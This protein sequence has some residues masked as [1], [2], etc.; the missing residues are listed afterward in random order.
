MLLFVQLLV[1][2]VLGI[3]GKHKP[4]SVVAA[5]PTNS[6]FRALR[7][8]ANSNES[9]AIFILAIAYCMLNGGSTEY[10]SY[11]AW[12]FVGARM[13]YAAC[14]YLDL[15]ILRSS[16]FGVSLLMLAALLIIG[17]FT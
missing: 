4:G 9:I 13:A 1:A 14:Y 3:L 5:D 15:R 17:T 7:T 8:V 6:L 10:T 2:D 12:G 16:V 11:A